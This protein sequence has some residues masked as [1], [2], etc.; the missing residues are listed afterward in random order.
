MEVKAVR[1]FKSYTVNT[2]SLF[3]K[4]KIKPH[5]GINFSLR[6]N[7]KFQSDAEFV[8]F[9]PV[10]DPSVD[11]LSVMSLKDEDLPITIFNN[12][13]K[14]VTLK[15]GSVLGVL[16]DVADSN[17]VSPD[18]KLPDFE[19]R[20][21]YADEFRDC[22]PAIK[23]ENFTKIQQ[24]LP[25]HLQDLLK[26]SCTHI[27]L[28][29]SVKLAN[30]LGEFATIFSK[31]DTDLGHFKA[32]YHRII[33]RNNDPIKARMRRTPIHFE[34]EEEANLT[35][36][37]DAGVITESCSEYAHPVCLVRKKDRSVRWCIDTRVLNS[38]TVKERFPLPKIEQCLHTLC[39]NR[40]VLTLD[41]AFGYWQIEIAP[42][43]QKKT[44]FITKYGLF[45]HKMMCFGLCN[46]PATFQRAMQFVLSGLLWDKAL[47]YLDDV[48]SLGSDFESVIANLRE[49]FGR[50]YC[51][52]RKELLAVIR[53]TWQFHYYLLGRNFIVRT[54]HNSLTWLMS[55]KN[56]EGQLARWMEELS[57]FDMSVVHRAGKLHANADALSGIP[58][59]L[60]YCPNYQSGMVLSKLP[61][62]SA[63]IRVNFVQ[64]LR[65]NGPILMK[66]WIMLFP[67]QWG[68]LLSL[69]ISLMV[70]P[71]FGFPG[72][73]KV[74]LGGNNWMIPN[75]MSL[76]GGLSRRPS[77]L[78]EI[79]RCK[80]LQ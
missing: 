80:V 36:M 60:E 20:T 32:V 66:M 6:L 50:R 45:E 14:T 63:E 75:L 64:G 42:E 35:K 46:G 24:T 68:K 26:R 1:P 49:I 22:Y 71:I 4:I 57:Q 74:G 40:Y 61:C 9:E 31:S 5:S 41:L 37:L 39:G 53:F 43:D 48:I 56:I 8:V 65:K 27:T 29:Q 7:S 25:D 16:A 77:L 17:V 79:Y 18:F 2:V 28:Y 78:R 34:A 12:T 67:Y 54:D 76:L 30:L 62:Y 38:Y 55:F 13:N 52:T 10:K 69:P 58:D 23:S 21:L 70:A 11:I 51:T 73:I 47:C 59:E 33:T 44:A 19:I 72:M 15:R 3:K